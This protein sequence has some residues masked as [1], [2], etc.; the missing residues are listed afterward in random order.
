MNQFIKVTVIDDVGMRSLTLIPAEAI[1]SAYQEGDTVLI[2]YQINDSS[3]KC[4]ALETIEDISTKL[5]R[6]ISNPTTLA[7][8]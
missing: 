5:T 7:V 6:L 1:T 8:A 2:W 3:F 4:R